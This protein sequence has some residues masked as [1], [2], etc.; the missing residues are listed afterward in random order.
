MRDIEVGGDGVDMLLDNDVFKSDEEE[1]NAEERETKKATTQRR[2]VN[3]MKTLDR[4]GIFGDLLLLHLQISLLSLV[5]LSYQKA[6]F[7]SFLSK[8]FQ[9]EGSLHLWWDSD[10]LYALR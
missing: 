7:L 8:Q 6:L 9:I 2:M 10:R 5:C 1:E 4:P 3:N